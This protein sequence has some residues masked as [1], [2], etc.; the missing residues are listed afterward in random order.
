MSSR[1]NQITSIV[2]FVHYIFF[3][4]RIRI[5]LDF[6]ILC[7]ISITSILVSH[8]W[9]L[10]ILLLC[11]PFEKQFCTQLSFKWVYL[12]I[13]ASGSGSQGTT[14]L[15][16]DSF[17]SVWWLFFLEVAAGVYSLP[18]LDG[19]CSS[20]MARPAYKGFVSCLLL[21]HDSACPSFLSSLSFSVSP[22]SLAWHPWR[23]G[24]REWESENRPRERQR[25][26]FAI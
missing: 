16:V 25:R 8:F 9:L 18:G 21:N 26:F 19:S 13:S 20:G 6:T 10:I 12:R 1:D 2:A 15:Y 22:T 7:E 5:L 3:P 11:L 17:I 14:E 4:C 23:E 24:G